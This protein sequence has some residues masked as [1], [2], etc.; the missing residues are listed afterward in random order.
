MGFQK[1]RCRVQGKIKEKMIIPGR[2]PLTD[3]LTQK[4]TIILGP[5]NDAV[6]LVGSGG[7]VPSASIIGIFNLEAAVADAIHETVQIKG[8]NVRS[9]GGR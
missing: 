8:R 1:G 3:P 9:A 4:R 6:N 5:E 2:Q 7:N